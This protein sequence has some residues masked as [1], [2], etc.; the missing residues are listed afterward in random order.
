MVKYECTICTYETKKKSDYNK[1]CKTIKHL[2]K[3]SQEGKL[4]SCNTKVHSNTT[5]IPQQN[6]VNEKYK[7]EYCSIIFSRTDSLTRHKRTC[8]KKCEEMNQLKL[9]F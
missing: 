6:R 3:V 8:V 7:C 5:V 4:K 1:H 2:Q 9:F